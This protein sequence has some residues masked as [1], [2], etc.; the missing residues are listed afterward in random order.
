MEKYVNSTGVSLRDRLRA[1]LY[2]L[3]ISAYFQISMVRLK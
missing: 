1:F 2:F 3:L